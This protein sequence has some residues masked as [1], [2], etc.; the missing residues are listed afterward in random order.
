MHLH[1]IDTRFFMMALEVAFVHDK[2][3]VTASRRHE[4]SEE[5]GQIVDDD[6]GV[7]GI[8]DNG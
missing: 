8:E 2:E 1:T 7:N 4:S 5:E 6:E 3:R